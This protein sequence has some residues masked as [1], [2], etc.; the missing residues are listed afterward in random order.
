[1]HVVFTSNILGAQRHVYVQQLLD[2][3]GE[4]LLIAHHGDIVQAIEVG[5]RLHVGLVLDQLFR[6]AVQEADVRIGAEDDLTVQLQDQPQHAVGGRMLRAEVKPHVLYGLLRQGGHCQVGLLLRRR[7]FEALHGVHHR[8]V[9]L[10]EELLV[11]VPLVA[12]TILA[13]N[14]G[15]VSR[16]VMPRTDRL[17]RYITRVRAIN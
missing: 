6:A 14:T 17:C 4:A 5:Q 2:R 7:P 11:R 3:Q 9:E 1:M 13:A 16:S 8:L 10:L 12:V 15:V